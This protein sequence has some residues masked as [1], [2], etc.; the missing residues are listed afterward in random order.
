MLFTDV[1]TSRTTAQFL[2]FRGFGLLR[3]FFA[4]FAFVDKRD[5]PHGLKGIL[6]YQGFGLEKLHGINY[7]HVFRLYI[8]YIYHLCITMDS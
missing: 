2:E 7:F 8:L 6:V 3:C 1:K 4:L 5:R